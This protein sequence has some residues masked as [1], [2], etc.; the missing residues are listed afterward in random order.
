MVACGVDDAWCDRV[1]GEQFFPPIDIGI[2]GH[3]LGIEL[4]G[5]CP[6]T[7]P[8]RAVLCVR[9]ASQ[10]RTCSALPG[11]MYIYI[12]MRYTTVCTQS[13]LLQLLERRVGSGLRAGHNR[14]IKWVR[15]FLGSVRGES[16]AR[17]SYVSN[18]FAC[19]SLS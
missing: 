7:P 2:E 4:R 19:T 14:V 1:E 11:N 9:C 16:A 8:F 12:Y 13:S 15:T 10:V 18:P 3:L 6:D 5:A 17:F